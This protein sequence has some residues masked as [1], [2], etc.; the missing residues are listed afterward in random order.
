MLNRELKAA[1]VLRYGTQTEAA[2]ELGVRENRLSR[3]IQGHD[4]PSTDE[5]RILSE[6][7]GVRLSTE[8]LEAGS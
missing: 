3:I 2:K 8:S 7:L 5:Q 4:K 6:R 1:I